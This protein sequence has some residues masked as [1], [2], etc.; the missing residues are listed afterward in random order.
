MASNAATISKNIFPVEIHMHTQ[1]LYYI[2]NNLKFSGLLR[3]LC[4]CLNVWVFLAWYF[5]A[6]LGSACPLLVVAYHST[7]NSFGLSCQVDHL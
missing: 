3:S 2:P 4:S 6:F 7:L 1:V 5:L